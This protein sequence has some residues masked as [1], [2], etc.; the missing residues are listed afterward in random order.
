MR[1]PYTIHHKDSDNRSHMYRRNDMLEL[2][3]RR[4]CSCEKS[5]AVTLYLLFIN[6]EE[7][8]LQNV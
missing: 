8:N 5:V 1:S 3:I 7:V 4:M 2:V 6:R